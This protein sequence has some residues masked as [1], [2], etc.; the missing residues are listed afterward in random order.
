MFTPEKTFDNFWMY[1]IVLNENETRDI[2]L[3]EITKIDSGQVSLTPGVEE[4]YRNRFGSNFDNMF[5]MPI[6]SIGVVVSGEILNEDTGKTVKPGR[7][8]GDAI[9]LNSPIEKITQ[10]GIAPISKYVCLYPRNGE[11]YRRK[12]YH[13]INNL[14]DEPGYNDPVNIVITEQRD[15]DQFI[16]I[17]SGFVTIP[18]G[19]SF[20]EYSLLRIKANEPSKTIALMEPNTQIINIWSE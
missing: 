11:F 4:I 8:N 12:L 14:P 7:D 16:F 9:I 18:G 2:S 1:S 17:A 10:K 5:F 19:K 20:G 3:R 15:K 13:N 6:I